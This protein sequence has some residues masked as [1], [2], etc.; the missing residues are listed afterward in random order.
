LPP[1]V[2]TP[3]ELA[4]LYAL[5][6]QIQLLFKLLKSSC[7]LDH[8]DTGDVNA[9]RT[10]IY[11]SILAAVILSALAQEA[12]KFAGLSPREISMLA[13]GVAAPLLAVPLLLLWLGRRPTPEEL[14]AIIMRTL[15]IG[16]RDQ[17]PRRTREKWGRL[18]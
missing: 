8:L 1:D 15:A 13:V 14:A 6:W 10:H 11:A 2:L 18:S 17:N 3:R 9:L 7:H 5:R 4:T 16:C 12:A